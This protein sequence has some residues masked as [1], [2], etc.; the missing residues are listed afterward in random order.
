MTF[1]FL[2][3][4]IF[5]KVQAT[6]FFLKIHHIKTT[7]WREGSNLN[8]FS[9][10]ANVKKNRKTGIYNKLFHTHN[11]TANHSSVIKMKYIFLPFSLH[12]S[13]LSSPRQNKRQMPTK[14][15]LQVVASVS[16]GKGDCALSWKKKNHL[17]KN[18]SRHDIQKKDQKK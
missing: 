18:H 14:K 12:L 15:L 3:I 5:L 1:F 8:H 9:W 6:Q 10:K 16:V 7:V 2:K 4:I 13:N 17:K 11:M